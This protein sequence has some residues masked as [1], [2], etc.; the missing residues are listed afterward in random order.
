MSAEMPVRRLGD[1]EVSVVGRGCNKVGRTVDLEGT[2]A[3]VDAALE[4]GVNFLDTADIYGGRG[5][6]ERLLGE[7]LQG[8]RDQ[9][10]LATKFGMDM[11]DAPGYPDAPRG[12][13]TYIA[14]AIERSLDR[15]QTDHIDLYQYHEPDGV[16]PI[17]ETLAAL[18]ELVSSGVVKNIGASNFSA[19]QL[20]EA[21][22]VA[23]KRGLTPFVSV[24]NRYSLLERGLE[25]D[26]T[27]VCRRLGVGILPFF[28]LANGVLTGKYRR[29]EPP[30]PGTRLHARG[31]TV[32]D[33]TFDRLEA[34]ERYAQARGLT[35]VDVA[36]GGLAAQ[37]MVA[38]VIAGA[39]KPEQVK[40]NAAAAWWVPTAEDL[41]ELDRIV[42]PG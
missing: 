8:R 11:G 13:R 12:S 25:A 16:T 40:A 33:E 17:E 22:A 24:Q 3:V 30:P 26:V 4:A 36:I 23:R 29:G 21:A 20:E 38:S 6:S 31:R 41:A 18:D 1:L 10:V 32:P 42:P 39:T 9:V 7:V 14:A 5:G 34:L 28:P 37:P 15:L 2:R 19:P 35:M 27:P